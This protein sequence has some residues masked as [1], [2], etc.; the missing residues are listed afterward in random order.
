MTEQP[1][2]T[3][4]LVFTDIEGSTL[5]LHVLGLD[6]YR[7]ALAEHGRTPMQSATKRDDFRHP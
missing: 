4:T 5:L 1:S 3:V 2:G 7:R 6:R